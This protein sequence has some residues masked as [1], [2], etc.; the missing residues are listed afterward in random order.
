MNEERLMRL[1]LDIGGIDNLFLDEL[2][3]TSELVATKE[4]TKRRVK[5]G[6]IVATAATVSAAVAFVM[7]KP[8][9]AARLAKNVTKKLSAA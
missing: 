7:L 5:Y 1:W 6:A 8:K 4:K 3:E 9:L 2:E